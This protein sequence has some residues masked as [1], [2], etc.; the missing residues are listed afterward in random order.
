MG[1][2]EKGESRQAEPC[3]AVQTRKWLKIMFLNGPSGYVALT[4]VFQHSIMYGAIRF[5]SKLHLLMIPVLKRVSYHCV[6]QRNKLVEL[7]LA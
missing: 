7:R 6:T 3:R 4:S 1:D 5:I 2:K